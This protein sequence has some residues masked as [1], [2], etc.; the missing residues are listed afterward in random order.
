M[1]DPIEADLKHIADQAAKA[2]RFH[3]G[4]FL[5]ILVSEAGQCYSATSLSDEQVHAVLEAWGRSPENMAPTAE[6]Q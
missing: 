5:V 2:T 1:T 3:R 4:E 6:V